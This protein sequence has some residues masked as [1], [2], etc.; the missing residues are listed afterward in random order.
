[1]KSLD[2]QD[3]SRLEHEERFIAESRTSSG[4]HEDGFGHKHTKALRRKMIIHP[5]PRCA[6]F[7]LSIYPLL[8]GLGV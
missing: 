5:Y 3:F 6:P 1:M 2:L 8:V 7:I 4:I